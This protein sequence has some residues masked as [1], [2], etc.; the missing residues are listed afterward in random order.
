MRIP[1]QIANKVSN[2]DSNM[3][4]N[5]DL[6]RIS[7]H[8]PIRIPTGSTTDSNMVSNTNSNEDFNA[9]SNKNSYWFHYRFQ[10]GVQ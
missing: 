9:Y 4:S 6:I 3:V 7:M 8:I 10:S 5:T 2:T 1:I